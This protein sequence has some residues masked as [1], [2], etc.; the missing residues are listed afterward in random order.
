MEK[1]PNAKN[2]KTKTKHENSASL[3]YDQWWQVV[4]FI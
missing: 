2:M 4:G 1:I 3:G